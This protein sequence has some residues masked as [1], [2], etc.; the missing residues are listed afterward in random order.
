V[1]EE[2]E[3]FE[4]IVHGSWIGSLIEEEERGDKSVTMQATQVKWSVRIL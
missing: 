4:D 1:E 2:E 3:V